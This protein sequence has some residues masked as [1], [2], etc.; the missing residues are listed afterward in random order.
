MDT[1]HFQQSQRLVNA[2]KAEYENILYSQNVSIDIFVGTFTCEVSNARLSVSESVK[3]NGEII[4]G[5]WVI[6]LVSFIV[7]FS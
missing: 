6:K 1:S 7:Y 5:Q 3:I 2:E 4:E